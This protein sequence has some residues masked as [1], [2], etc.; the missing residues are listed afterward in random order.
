[1]R[2]ASAEIR[3]AGRENGIVGIQHGDA[4]R[5]TFVDRGLRDIPLLTAVGGE[6]PVVLQPEP[7]MLIT[8]AVEQIEE[9]IDSR[10]PRAALHPH[11]IE[12]EGGKWAGLAD[13]PL[14]RDRRHAVHLR[15]SLEPRRDV[16]LVADRGIVEALGGAEIADAAIARIDA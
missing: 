2:W 15:Q 4:K 16:Y 8:V 7:R 9:R 12:L 5:A 14:A 3:D 13:G 1:G 6:K 10:R 11:E